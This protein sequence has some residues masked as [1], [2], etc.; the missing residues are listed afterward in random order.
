MLRTCIRENYHPRYGKIT[1]P[2][3]N[4]SA[5]NVFVLQ[6]GITHCY[7]VSQELKIK[8]TKPKRLEFSSSASELP[9]LDS[10]NNYPSPIRASTRFSRHHFSSD[11]DVPPSSPAQHSLSVTPESQYC[12]P[13]NTPAICSYVASEEVH[14]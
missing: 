5:G 2:R 6:Y 1:Q 4:M 11:T 14:R 13:L 8:K 9:S 3:K 10:L 12:G 7:F